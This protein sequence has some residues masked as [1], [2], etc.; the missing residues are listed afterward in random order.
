MNKFKRILS[1]LLAV[2]MCL[3]LFSVLAFADETETEDAATTDTSSETATTGGE[4]K[5]ELFESSD[6]YALPASFT[7]VS[8]NKNLAFYLDYSSGEYALY[9]KK[10]STYLFSNPQ[11]RAVDTVA[12]TETS[13]YADSQMSVTY[14]TSTF[15]VAEAYSGDASIITE[16][17]GDSQII[18]YFFDSESTSFIIPIMFTLKDE[19]LEVEVLIDSINEMGESR[20]QT[21]SL[22]YSFGAGNPQDDGYVLL[23]DGMGSLMPFN[24]T[25]QNVSVYNGYVYAKDPTADVS[26]TAYS[27]GVDLTETIHLPVYGIK[28]NNGGY[29]AIITQ[30]E[31]NVSLKAYCAG[32]LNSYNFVYPTINIRDS[33][34]RRTGSGNSGAGVYY[35]DVLPQNLVMRVYPLS[36]NNANYVGMANI[37]REYLTNEAGLEPLAEDTETAMNVSVIG[38]YKRTKHF[39]G[40]P[41]TG[42]DT[43]TTFE[44]T[45][46]ILTDLTDLGVDN[47]ICGMIGWND[48]GL[49]DAV[50]T[51]FDPE[52]SL[53]GE[54]GAKNLLATAEEL[55]IPLAFD[56]DLV[57]FFKPTG[58]YTK[59]DSTVYGL[60]MSP[61]AMFPF[62]VSLNRTD[63]NREEHYLFHPA[64]MLSIASSFVQSASGFGIEN[65]SFN[66]IGEEPYAAYN[67]DNTYTRDKTADA[68]TTLFNNVSEQTDGIITTTGGN[69][70]SFPAVNNVIEAPLYSSELYYATTEVP[71]Y[72]IALR[73][74]VRL[75][76]P[77]FNL[78][79]ETTDLILRSAQY[80]VGLY[81]V[82]SYESSSNL[83]DT[84]YNYYYSTQYSLWKDD[85]V[86]A[87]DRLSVVYDAV[88]TSAI[89]DYTIVS[90]D[91]KITTFANG[92][93]V[94]V[95]YGETDVTYKG[96][97]IAAED[98]TVVGGD[99]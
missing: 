56:V 26:L 72:Y 28:K 55:D 90:E 97:K 42:V 65:F 75:S 52:A 45:E 69:A 79:S 21:I 31:A 18:S 86:N 32:M 83:K 73:G 64:S 36:G 37:Y 17:Y 71:F 54:Q 85:I 24:E 78:N 43:M 27:Y 63:R 88:G 30:S 6:N 57:N 2:V 94:Y 3:S 92:A 23:P 1:L 80:G 13:K 47:M 95:N 61:V 74:L 96:V 48:G 25:Y 34:T 60:D 8:E 44:Q 7:K 49:E 66:T 41:Y 93:K 77:A 40:I 84:S 19:Y 58:S 59:Y 4:V 46:E 39:L 68:I 20:V 16:T 89:T 11:D 14:I 38:A 87:Y 82:L 70:Y 91:L 81:V 10:N 67:T 62:I 22:M 76:G 51:S 12:N 53:G 29:V 98:F 33:Q 99:K 15:S 35:S 9:N 50:S 5:P